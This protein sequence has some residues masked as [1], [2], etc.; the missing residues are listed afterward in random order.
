MRKTLTLLLVVG[1]FALQAISYFF[2]AAPIG[3]PINE[4]FSNP[5]VPF[6]AGIFVLGV[7]LVFVAALVYELLPGQRGD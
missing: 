5:R 1:G 3:V 7:V 2:L 6:A 4:N